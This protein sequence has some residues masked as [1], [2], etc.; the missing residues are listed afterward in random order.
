MLESERN[1]QR[2]EETLVLGVSKK[3][4]KDEGREILGPNDENEGECGVGCQRLEAQAAKQSVGL[5]GGWVIEK[6]RPV[7]SA[8]S[9]PRSTFKFHLTL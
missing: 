6:A 2:W 9:V 7:P 5:K 3:K 1:L 8:N 4:K